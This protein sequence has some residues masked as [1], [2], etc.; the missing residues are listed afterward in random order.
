MSRQVVHDHDVAGAERG[1][2][3]LL[4]VGEEGWSVHR[5]VEHHRRAHAGAAQPGGERGGLLT[6]VRYGSPT[7]LAAPESAAQARHL[8]EAPVSSMKI[9]LAGSRSSWPSNQ[10]CRAWRTASRCCSA[11]WA[12]FFV[13]EAVPIEELPDA[14]DPDAQA[15]LDLETLDELG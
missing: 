15:A 2:E 1:R 11:A 9:S 14:G 3:H 5:P 7:A 10:A 12:V 6:A 4:Y 13:R 8:G